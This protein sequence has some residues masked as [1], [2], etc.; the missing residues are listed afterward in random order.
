MKPDGQGPRHFQ[1]IHGFFVLGAE[2]V[3]GFVAFNPQD[4]EQLFDLR[5]QAQFPVQAVEQFGLA[6]LFVKLDA[7]E[8]GQMLGQGFA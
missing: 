8:R 7:G 4:M 2:L 1:A 5:F 6:G 3:S